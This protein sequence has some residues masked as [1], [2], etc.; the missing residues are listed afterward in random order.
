[1]KIIDI[2]THA[3]PNAIAARAIAHLA[4]RDGIHPF[5]DGTLRGLDRSRRRAGIDLCVVLSVATRP[6]QVPSIN[7]WILEPPD[8]DDILGDPRESTIFFGGMH[9]YYE[10]YEAEIHR[11]R[12]ASIRGVKLHPNFQDFLPDDP[13]FS[14]LFRTLA[15]EGMIALFHAGKDISIPGAP[16]SPERL[17]RLA[18]RFP[19]LTM[20]CAHMGG[21]EMWDDV[22]RYLLGRPNV[23]LDTAFVFDC[24]D[25]RR[26]VDLARRHGVDR[27]LFGTD[28]PWREQLD[29]VERM[30]SL[31]LTSEELNAIMWKNASR[32]L[33]LNELKLFAASRPATRSL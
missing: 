32:L 15:R 20:I 27:I 33:R 24:L 30:R 10:D 8:P 14:P 9:P 1:M 23:Y 5:H 31:P 3:F 4:E 26:F 13:A 22:E 16:G 2:H 25:D 12:W 21:W 7:R 19:D 29:D 18:D 11:L 17:A 28:T 6:S